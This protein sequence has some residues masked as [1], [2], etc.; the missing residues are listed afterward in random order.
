MGT[1]NYKTIKP[2][3]QID[4]MACWAASLEWWLKYMSPKLPVATQWDLMIDFKS[5]TYYPED[6][7]DPNF[8][9]LSDSGMLNILNA[10]RFNLGTA[11]KSGPSMTYEFLSEKLKNG[12]VIIAFLDWVAA[13]G[14][15]GETRLNHCN[16]VI[17]AK[18]TE[19][20][21]VNLTVMEPRKGTFEK[22]RTISYY[23][24]GDVI[25][26]WPKI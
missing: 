3:P 26:G 21:V 25:L 4:D 7:N 19:S 6:I 13:G 24:Q 18:K 22:Y 17:K 10:P 9:G 11:Y 12:P 2:V 16:V 20:G 15:P 14:S 5:E 23:Q 1:K 8:G